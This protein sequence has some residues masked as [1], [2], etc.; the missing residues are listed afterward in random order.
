[1]ANSR[2]SMLITSCN[3]HDLLHTTLDSFFLVT[4]IEPQEVIVYEDSN[5]PMPEWLKTPTWRAREVKWIQGGERRG[6]AFACACLI[7]EARYEWTLWMEDDWFFQKETSDFIRES[8]DILNRHP[9]VIQVSLRGDSGWHPL[10]KREDILIAEPNWRGVWGGWSWNPGLRRTKELKEI[11]LPL[12]SRQIGRS[13]LVH[14]ENVSKELL[15]QGR[16]IADLGR[17]VVTHIGGGRSRAVESLPP[18][19]RILIAVPTCFAFDYETHGGGE[20]CKITGF[21]QNGANEQTQAVRDTWGKDVKDFQNVDLRFFYGKPKDGYPRQPLDDEVFLD[22]ADGYDSL[23]AKTHGVCKWASENDY[24]IIFKAD[25]DT[26][27]FVDRLIVEIMENRFDYAGYLHGGVCSGGPGYL[28]SDRA[29]RIVSDRGKSPQHPYAEDVHVS[30]VLG[31]VGINPL[32]LP[33]HVPGFGA[34]FF[35]PEGFD[36]TRLSDEIVSMHALFPKEMRDCYAHHHRM[37]HKNE[38]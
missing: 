16:V 33:N 22:V 30:R 35:F 19:P 17:P 15:D 32:M 36:P 20:D 14:E 9:E 23:I 25:T 7:R 37:D 18:L 26:Y 1:M 12:I 28:L 4:D 34:H 10:V 24:K 13:G 38:S 27:V 3:R 29:A 8:K 31:S 5:T 2:I 6:Q 11:I 21:H